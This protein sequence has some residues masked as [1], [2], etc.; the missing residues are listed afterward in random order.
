MA[1]GASLG[2]SHPASSSLLN[3]PPLD[4]ALTHLPQDSSPLPPS[5]REEGIPNLFLRGYL[6]VHKMVTAY[7]WLLVAQQNL[8]VGVGAR[9][10]KF[11][12]SWI[13]IFFLY[14]RWE[15]QYY[16]F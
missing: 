14:R 8:A 15:I 13:A 11:S 7:H 6:C 9:I 5:S 12:L 4:I 10:G 16:I 3:L 2:I 1:A